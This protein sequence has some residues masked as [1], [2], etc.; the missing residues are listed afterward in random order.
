M[1]TPDTAAKT[2]PVKTKPT[3]AKPAPPLPAPIMTKRDTVLALLRRK[4]GATMAELIAATG[5]QAHSIR[6]LLSRL[7]SQGHQITRTPYGT[8]CYYALAG[9]A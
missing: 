9:Q 1:P 5:W 6:A 4:G 2:A 7:G 8:S 3:A